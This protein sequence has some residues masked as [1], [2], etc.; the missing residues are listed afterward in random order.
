MT[1][2][3]YLIRQLVLLVA[4]V[5]V[6]LV[7]LQG[8]NLRQNSQHAR[9]AA[10]RAVENDAAG[11]AQ[12]IDAW[13][14]D[15]EQY[16][17]FLARRPLIQ[18]L[19]DQQ[20]D[21]LLE[22][23]AKR[24]RHI[25]NVF[26]VD[27][28]G[29]AVCFSVK[30]PGTVPATLA[31]FRWF[32]QAMASDAIS[33]SK[34]FKAPVVQKMVSAMSQPLRDASGARIGTVTVL[35]DLES[36][37]GSWSRFS[38]P[39]NSRMSV[40][41]ADGT[42]IITRPD[43]EAHVGREA[44]AT[45][46]RALAQGKGD[47][48][49][50]PGIDG[51]ERAFS[52]KPVPH[53]KW[54]VGVA[55]PTAAV[56]G[57]AER[58]FKQN[59]AIT[60]AVLVV[61]VA[62]A[63]FMAR[64]LAAPLSGLVETA[65][66]I[67]GGRS[68]LRASENVPGEFREVAREFNAMLDANERHFDFYAALSRTNGAIVRAV[69]AGELYDQICRICVEHGH[70]SIAYVSLVEG[71]TMR[72]VA[73]AGPADD[74]VRHLHVKIADRTVMGS[75]LSGLAAFTG[76]RQISNDVHE[77]P[78]T[79]PW[80]EFGD[81]IGTQSI[82]ACPFS[83]G[84]RTAGTL[85]L[86]MTSVGF[87]QERVLELLDEMTEDISFALD[88]FAR[89][90]ALSLHEQQ[91]AGLV[92]TAM[93]AI[94][95]I[96]R[97]HRIRLFNRAASE[98]FRVDAAEVLG[99]TLDRFIPARLR[100]AHETHLSQFSKTGSTAR[101]MG[102][103]SLLA[104]RAD[105][106]EFPIEAS[107]SRLGTGETELMTVV[108]RDATALRAAQEA[109]LAQVTAE[110]AS[111]AKTDFLSRMSHELRTP[112]NAVLGF[113]QLLQTDDREPL[114]PTQYDHADRIRIAGWHLLALINDVLDVS[115]IEAGHL[116]LDDRKVDLL[117][118]LDEAIRITQPGAT[119]AKVRIV[120]GY[121][122]V[123]AASVWADPR[124]LRQIMLNLLS[125]AIKYN[126][127]D[128]TVDV[129]VSADETDTHIDVI[130]SGLGMTEAQLE[131]LYEP[132]NRLGREREGIEGTGLGLSLA[133]QLV[134]LMRGQIEVRSAVGVG[135]RVRVT[136]RSNGDVDSEQAALADPMRM[137]LADAALPV[138]VVLYIE[139]NPVN[140]MLVEHLLQRW[141]AV[142]LLHAENGKNGLAI[143]G[144]AAIDLVLLDMRLPDMNGLDVLREIRQLDPAHR[145]RVVAL[146]ASAM[147]EEVKAA[148]TAGAI[149]YW[150]KPL[151][152]AQFLQEMRRLLAPPTP[153]RVT[154]DAVAD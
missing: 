96:D 109:R 119:E 57:P 132:F 104:L 53:A 148:E 27:L 1:Q 93:D 69:D 121:R 10:Y 28:T 13:L 80:R 66:A 47:V 145:C 46:E 114:T 131:H 102:T 16:L 90:A 122:K 113:S 138:G 35:L 18:A 65:R 107:I 17:A 5:A 15:T 58:E 39:A 151:D 40:F 67:R 64:R 29:K 25:A 26:V 105:G 38:L 99:G 68:E 52:L 71:E 81:A 44:R 31:G 55:I 136:L 22:G 129:R 77:D 3:R 154:V 118:A 43:F 85:T 140:F 139:D 88:N 84:G 56:F 59:V 54:L 50:A 72:H 133:R 37:H 117:E 76:T 142:T 21:P 89:G 128:G 106:S 152:F 11:I 146:S 4:A 127:P 14:A 124:R 134:H 23:V 108:I 112:L 33:V 98:M 111:R 75:G 79:L 150:T 147:P 24:R 94:I 32:Q 82:A 86:H 12:D 8:Y 60:S 74:F 143:L 42:I 115:K 130:D 97:H 149:H 48:G 20:C 103:H 30:G 36:M 110:S 91:L 2:P 62:I 45:V 9:E 49:I 41:D 7:L 95:S 6:P 116:T 78:R 83:R 153:E 100:P 87:F 120:P 70:A 63:F 61:V 141:P 51:V 144:A 73:W 101:R 125:N 92:E 123:A 34:P 137:D 135:T 126:R 19:D